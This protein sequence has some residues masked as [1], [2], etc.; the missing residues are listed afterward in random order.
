MILYLICAHFSSAVWLQV[1]VYRWKQQLK[2]NKLLLLLL[3][4]ANRVGNA[5][6]ET[7]FFFFSFWVFRFRVVHIL[8][9]NS[10]VHTAHIKTTPK[11]FV[12]SRVCRKS[13]P[14]YGSQ[15]FFSQHTMRPIPF[16]A[17]LVYGDDCRHAPTLF[18]ALHCITCTGLYT[19]FFK[20]HHST[21]DV[22]V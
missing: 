19:F 18:S 4:C 9:V 14:L 13:L 10:F 3:F 6:S 22:I 17:W 8:S 20:L 2:K 5:N 7:F 11:G 21:F 12:T 16:V 1:V 15:L